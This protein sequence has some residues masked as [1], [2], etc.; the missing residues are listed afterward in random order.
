MRILSNKSNRSHARECA[1]VVGRCRIAVLSALTQLLKKFTESPVNEMLF[2]ELPETR[3]RQLPQFEGGRVF[4][5]E[6]FMLFVM[7]VSALL[8]FVNDVISIKKITVLSESVVIFL[9]IN[10]SCQ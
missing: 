6:E 5:Q 9:T 8:L 1:A 4:V 7:F 3:R 2:M 10:G